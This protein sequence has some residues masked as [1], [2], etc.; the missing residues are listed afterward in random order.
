MLTGRSGTYSGSTGGGSGSS[1]VPYGSCWAQSGSPD[2]ATSLG[3]DGGVNFLS[4]GP[5]ALF[6]LDLGSPLAATSATGP[7]TLY[8]ETCGR[9]AFDTVLFVCECK[10]A[11]R[12]AFAFY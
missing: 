12:G 9:T 3:A 11:S 1:I 4:P 8:I 5:Q 2:Y 10:T 7:E 6:A